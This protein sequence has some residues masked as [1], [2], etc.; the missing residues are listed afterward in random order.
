MLTS[1]SYS[2][3]VRRQRRDRLYQIQDRNQSY[4]NDLHTSISTQLLSMDDAA[5][6]SL[7]DPVWILPHA[8]VSSVDP[9]TQQ[10]PS[11]AVELLARIDALILDGRACDAVDMLESTMPAASSGG[12]SQHTMAG[13]ISVRMHFTSGSVYCRYHVNH[14]STRLSYDIL[15]VSHWD[16]CCHLYLFMDYRSCAVSVTSCITLVCTGS[17]TDRVCDY[18][19][20]MR[21]SR[22]A[23]RSRGRC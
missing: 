21:P 7:I 1:V 20:G 19:A 8:D 5:L 2:T 22:E 16:I 4:L 12:A 17:S 15:I 23:F 14:I 13:M 18:C 10:L 9:L 6:Q 11:A 3:S